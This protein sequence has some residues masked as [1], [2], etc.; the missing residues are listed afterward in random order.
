MK[1]LAVYPTPPKLA[2]E[3]DSSQAPLDVDPGCERCVLHER[4]RTVCMSPELVAGPAGSM[5]RPTVL[6]VGQGPGETEDRH[7]RPNIGQS[8]QYLRDQLKKLWTG[9]V[10]FD[11]AVRCAPGARK[12]TPPMIA[13][14]RPYL[15]RTVVEAKPDRILCLGAAA[16]QAVVGRG[17]PPLSV[18]RGYTYLGDTPVFFL[19][20]PVMSLRNRFMRSWFEKDLAWALAAKPTRAPLHAACLMIETQ[21]DAQDAIEDMKLAETVTWDLETFGAPFNAE[22]DILNL[23]LTPQDCDYAYVL[24]KQQLDDPTIATPIFAYLKQAW[25]GGQNIKFDVI[26]L[27]ARYGVKVDRI[28]FD[29]MLWRRILNADALARLEYQQAM[30]GMAGDKDEA[31]G[32]VVEGKKELRKMVKKPETVP[33]LFPSIPD[34]H[35]ALALKRIA[36]GDKSDTYAYA[37]IPPLIRSVYNAKD[38]ISTERVRAWLKG[39]FDQRPDLWRVWDS[40][41][42]SLNYAVTQMEYNGIA[43]SRPAVEQLR[44]AMTMKVDELQLRLNQHSEVPGENFSANS[45]DQVGKLLFET[46]GLPNKG[47][48]PTGKWK[49]TAEILTALG[50]PAADDIINFRKASKFRSQYANGMAFFIRDDRRIHPNYQIAGTGT[51]RLSCAGPNLFNIPRPTSPEGKM[52]RD[53]FVAPDGHTLME[54]DYS[55]I[56][57]RVAAMLSGDEVMIQ[58]FKDGADFHLETAKLIAPI[59]NLNPDDITKEH[60]LRDHAKTINFATLYGSPPEGMAAQLGVSVKMAKQLHNAILGKFVKLKAWI[61][62]SLAETRKTGVARTWWDGAPFRERPL[63]AVGDS[64]GPARETA[65]R[66]SWNTAVQ[67]TATEYTNASLGAIQS[68]LEAD[69]VPAKMVLTV[70]DSIMLEVRD[71]AIDEVAT[72]AKA[73][74]EGWPVA[75]DVPII[76]DLKMGRAWGSMQA[77]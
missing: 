39:G 9:D 27:H 67:G 42:Q 63:Y 31:A 58:F 32:F 65:E 43:V 61:K 23:A 52:C 5:I 41:V 36:A 64:D 74:M 4:A 68:W 15:A 59:F 75:H 54:F 29:T 37:A 17:F 24:E 34:G 25:S 45:S 60:E 7:G 28:A 35:M 30:V 66:S 44:L 19:F 21:A 18:R 22:Y 62:V 73:I 14:C 33:K 3:D 72:A 12:V 71:D 13:A 10:V 49:C 48:T 70:Y 11:N 56:E 26:G 40:V 16:I 50:N 1:T 77:A 55:Q 57:L 76:S 51:G 47:R 46:L 20:H 8:G 69:F 2:V 38:T 6:V 53:I